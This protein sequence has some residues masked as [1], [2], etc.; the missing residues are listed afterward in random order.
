M[1]LSWIIPAY[2]EEKRIEKTILEVDRYLRGQ[3]FDYE[4]IVVD[5]GSKDTTSRVVENLKGPI[6]NLKLMKTNGP[7]KG[8]AVRA[9][10][11]AA[12]GENRIFADAD[13]SVSP[14]QLDSFLPYV[15]GLDQKPDSCFDVVIGS[16]EAEGAV[17]EEH[18]QWYRRALGKFSKYIIRFFAGLWEIRDTQRGFKLFSRRAAEIIFPRQRITT[19]GFDIEVLVIAKKHGFRIKEL[20]VT[21][22]NPGDSKVGLGAYVSTFMELLQIVWNDVRGRYR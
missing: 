18:A 5:N 8:W 10:M 11:L 4:I 22:V 14:G 7:G 6:K 21:W 20:P 17:I 13:N 19:W 1:Y 16:I 15:C 9:G 3:N 12:K 2:N